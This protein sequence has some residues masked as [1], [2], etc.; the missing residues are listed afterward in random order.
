[1]YKVAALVILILVGMKSIA[2]EIESTSFD[3][4]D[5]L[6]K[7]KTKDRSLQSNTADDVHKNVFFY[8]TRYKNA[9]KGAKADVYTGYFMIVPKDALIVDKSSYVKVLFSDGS[10]KEYKH[11]GVIK[12][13]G[14]REPATVYMTIKE[15]DPLMVKPIQAVRF[16]YNS[17]MLDFDITSDNFDF[18]VKSIKMLRDISFK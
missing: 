14:K 6:Y 16:G 1:M 5:S 12:T 9:K 7:A 4:F 13:Y 18:I 2:Q 17:G 10:Q 8:A 3:K 15:G 11:E